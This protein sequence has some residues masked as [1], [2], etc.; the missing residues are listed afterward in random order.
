[1]CNFAI[2]SYHILLIT[3]LAQKSWLNA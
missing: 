2:L 1:M 3:R